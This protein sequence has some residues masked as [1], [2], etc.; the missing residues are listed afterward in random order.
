VSGPADRIT[1]P[2]EKHVST[3]RH[4]EIAGAGFAGL[5]TAVALSQ[6]GWS[7][8]VHERGPELREFGAG[9][10]LWP[11]GM[12]VLEAIGAHESIAEVSHEPPY[13]ETRVDDE[14]VSREPLNGIYRIMTRQHLYQALLTAAMRHGVEIVVDSEVA[15]ADPG[16]MLTLASGQS[17]RADLV[18][19]ADGVGSRVRSSLG[20][21]TQ[22][23]TSRDG[24]IRL[25]VPRL[26]EALGGEPD[27]D[28]AMDF[29]T[30]APEYRRVLYNPCNEEDL[31]IALGSPHDDAVATR[32]PIDV[33]L[34]R[35]AFPQ[36][37]PVI[38]AAAGMQGRY[39]RYQTTQV[40]SWSRG[41]VA[42]VGDAAHA[43]CPAMGQGA[44]CAMVNALALAVA[45]EASPRI[46]QALQTWERTER[47]ITDRCQ[48]R[49]AEMQE[50]RAGARGD[51]LNPTM[52]EAAL[53]VPTGTK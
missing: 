20:L 24:I 38:E 25:L 48:D 31:Y 36:L 21:R 44:N 39:D 23:R 37:A 12:R 32:S 16:G 34:W 47:P 8:R 29:Y 10:T 49:S 5:T 50:G 1:C 15:A 42:L 7:V 11:N 27:W 9:I 6:R 30:F 19:G 35:S 3:T 52:L 28:N 14:T 46:E 41:R 33:D 17:A 26:K 18:V 4:A 51:W 40:E 53:H 13:F 22:R 43:M 2:N 45:V